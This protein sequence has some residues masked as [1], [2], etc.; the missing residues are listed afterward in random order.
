M[1]T[2]T[3][4]FVSGLGE[5]KLLQ[6]RSSELWRTVYCDYCYLPLSEKYYSEYHG[7]KYSDHSFVLYNKNEPVLYFPCNL[8]NN[9]LSW[10]EFPISIFCTIKDPLILTEIYKLLE[11]FLEKLV[12]EKSV[13][14]LF[15]YFNEYLTRSFFTKIAEVKSHHHTMIDLQIPE[16]NIKANIRKSNKT[17]VNWGQRE[18]VLKITDHS[19]PDRELFNEFHDF[20]IRTAGRKT[21]SDESWNTQYEMVLQGQA[22]FVSAYYKDKIASNLLILHGLEEAY[23]GVAVN[24]REL[25]EK[26][27]PI[28]HYPLLASVYHAKKIGLKKF[29]FNEVDKK[30]DAK[31]DSISNFKLGYSN[32][33]ELKTSYIFK[34]N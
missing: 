13:S 20:H 33:L 9:R 2:L 1:S 23:Y 18:L 26:N 22:F 4:A 31:M 10:F 25:M 3:P 34:F 11:S 7:G 6:L 32:W 16:E 30:G 14:E 15:V 28:T 8:N 29:N 19:N 5:E 17:L 27:E 12:R 24:D 21:R